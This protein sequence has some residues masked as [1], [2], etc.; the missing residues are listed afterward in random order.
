MGEFLQPP[1]S[2]ENMNEVDEEQ[3]PETPTN[4][5]VAIVLGNGTRPNLNGEMTNLTFDAK[6]RVLVGGMLAQQGKVK[7]LILT[8]GKTAG[9]DNPSE[10]EVMKSYLIKKFPELSEFPIILDELSIDTF[11]NAKFT[12]QKLEGHEGS[13]A[14]ITNDYH[15]SRAA[16]I[17]KKQGIEIT[18]VPAEEKV[19]ERSRHYKQ[20]M[21]QY[22]KSNDVKKKRI[23]EFGLTG[24]M[25]FDPDGKLITEIA[26][27][28]R[29][30]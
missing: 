3:S 4:F 14:L 22:L 30:G 23:I 20:L 21:S 15:M 8:G 29:G 26:R 16:K 10:A 1:P 9:P 24:I 6:L 13:A 5:D 25:R 7:E 28:L 18:E 11:E 27:R 19:V 17:F 2:K 12:A